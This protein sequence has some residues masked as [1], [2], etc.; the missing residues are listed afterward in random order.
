MK[1]RTVLERKDIPEN[2]KWDIDNIYEDKESLMADVQNVREKCRAIEKYKN[3]VADSAENLYNC[4]KLVDEAGI[5]CDRIVAYTNMKRDEDNTNVHGQELGE[6]G[7]KIYVEFKTDISFITPEIINAGN[8]KINKFFSDKKELSL[9]K[10]FIENIM[11][12]KKHYLSPKEEKIIAESNEMGF[13][14]ENIFKMLSFADIK[15]PDI[16]NESGDKLPLTTSNFNVYLGSKDRT[17]RKNAFK[18]LYGKIGEF[19]NTYGSIYGGS[20]KKDIFYAKERGFKSSLEAPL[21][22]DNIPE[23]LYYNVID[24]VSENIDKL[25]RYCEM[26]KK[27]LGVDELHLYDLYAPIVENEEMDIEFDEAKKMV[28][29]GLSVLGDDYASIL[30][31]EFSSRWIDVCENRGKYSGAYSSGSFDIKPYILL[32]YNYRLTDVLTLAHESGHSV[33]T[34][35]SKKYQPYIYSNYTIFCAEI[36]STTNEC[37]MYLYLMKKLKGDARK[38]IINN[39]LEAMRTVYYRQ[40]MFAEFE[41]K[42]HKMAENGE[43]VNGDNLSKIWMDLYKKYYGRCCVLDKE[44]EMEWARIPHF[45]SAFYVYKYVTGMSA[46]ISFA[47]SIMEDSKNRERYFEFLKSGGSSYSLDL[48]KKAGVDMTSKKP[49]ED[50]AEMFNYLLN[51]MK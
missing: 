34:Y 51:E 36:A 33:H 10:F 37:L 38:Y 16:E 9:Y 48:L 40:T 22:V 24:T 43:S 44:I 42:A 3:Q 12:Q 49:L 18:S 35:L 19:K 1:K 27:Y 4:L 13:G 25:D 26:K 20:I 8:E 17:I 28:L 29:E 32:N 41:L 39:F 2:L 46:A 6:I 23:E 30:K 45:Y 50:T 15:Y 5:I 47:K 14:F 21:F 7:E 11:R 31:E